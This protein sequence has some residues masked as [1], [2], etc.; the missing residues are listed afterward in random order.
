MRHAS[1]FLIEVAPGSM[2]SLIG[3][4]RRGGVKRTQ[5]I[6]VKRFPDELR[7]FS[8]IADPK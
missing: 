3:S 7:S 6:F 2:S 8:I 4:T 1:S 5:T